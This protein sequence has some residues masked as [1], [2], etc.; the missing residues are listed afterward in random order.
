[1][2]PGEGE[3]QAEMR[4]VRQDGGP[5]LTPS[6][7]GSAP[8]NRYGWLQH[9]RSCMTSNLQLLPRV[10]L[11][12]VLRRAAH[13]VRTIER[14]ER[15]CAIRRGVDLTRHVR[16]AS[17]ELNAQGTCSDV[18]PQFLESAVTRLRQR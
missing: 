13:A 7:P 16:T 12:V 9:L 15:P 5:V 10:V 8:G 2:G 6:K 3:S 18:R 4:W 14:Q 11:L 17:E 1:M